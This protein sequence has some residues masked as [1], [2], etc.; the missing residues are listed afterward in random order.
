MP[1]TEPIQQ[2]G[3]RENGPAFAVV[4][5][6]REAP[7]VVH[8][9]VAHYAG[10]GAA[11]IFVIFDGAETP[12][13]VALR[14]E[15]R[16][17]LRFVDSDYWQATLGDHAKIFERRLRHAAALAKAETTAP[18]LLVVDVD[19][20]LIARTPVIEM[21]ASIPEGVESFSIPPVE[22]VWGPGDDLLK[23]YG[24][25]WFR[26]PIYNFPLR[27]VLEPTVYGRDSMFFLHNALG[28]TRGKHFL[29]TNAV[30]DE[31]RSHGS[32]RHGREITISFR[33]NPVLPAGNEIAHFDAISFDRWHEKFRRRYSGEIKSPTMPPQRRAQIRAIQTAF[34]A[35]EGNSREA[36]LGLFRRFYGLSSRQAGIL[37]SMGFAFRLPMFTA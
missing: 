29:R 26:R 36:G 21:L 18:W 8:R 11:E 16:L 9:F 28:H 25:T 22:A 4:C 7:E 17:D 20:L 34:S 32:F 15:P 23:P 31:I 14:A 33:D 27:L 6:A 1:S 19:E 24:S 10:L 12:D 3:D 5:M 13:L 37:Q 30:V 35:D 2:T